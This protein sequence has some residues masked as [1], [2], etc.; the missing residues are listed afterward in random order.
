MNEVERREADCV[1]K[2]STATTEV[3]A[4]M[5]SGRGDVKGDK[6]PFHYNGDGQADWW[7]DSR[8]GKDQCTQTSHGQT[9]L[10]SQVT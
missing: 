1:Q 7:V 5:L 8:G 3:G 10:P 4:T 6:I 2:R 9:A